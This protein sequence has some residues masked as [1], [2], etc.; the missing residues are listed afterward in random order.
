MK[1]NVKKGAQ[2]VGKALIA[3]P[4]TNDF[5]QKT[6]MTLMDL[7]LFCKP[8]IAG[9]AFIDNCLIDVARDVA[10]HMLMEKFKDADYLFF[11]DSDNAFPPEVLPVLITNDVDICS[12]LYF[13]RKPPFGPIAFLKKPDGHYRKYHEIDLD[14]GPTRVDAVGMGCCLIKRRVVEKMFELKENWW[15]LPGYGEDISFCHNATANGFK[16]Y[17]DPRCK[18]EH[19]GT[20]SANES[21]VRSYRNQNQ[22]QSATM[23]KGV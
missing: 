16:V 11:V 6:V 23:P 1:A 21:F 3:L 22:I 10:C 9:R 20:F 7:A 13:E 5:E 15:R 14:A 8:F 12:G 17:V 18:V 4:N 19:I 2:K